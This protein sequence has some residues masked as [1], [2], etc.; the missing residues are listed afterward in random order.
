MNKRSL[1]VLLAL[2]VVLPF[3]GSL[4]DEQEMGKGANKRAKI[5]SM[6]QEA[7]DRL[8]EQSDRAQELYSQAAGYAVFSNV[9]VS[10]G[11]TGGGGKGVAVNNAAGSRTYMK[12]AT[13]GLNLGLGGQAYQVVF[14]FQDEKGLDNFVNKGWEAGGSANAVAG[15]AGANA[16]ASF[17]NGMAVYQLTKAGL[18][19]QADISG[20]KYWKTS[21]N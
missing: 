14:L 12:M 15:P 6:A 9:K 7:L 5:D 16:Q 10:L 2:L 4:A 17:T 21:L 20:T 1:V 18:M 8:F 3:T 11:V 13:G 19:L